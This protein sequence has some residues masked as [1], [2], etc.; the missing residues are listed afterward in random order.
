MSQVDIGDVMGLSRWKVGRVIKNARERKLISIAINHPQSDLTEIEIALAK[1]FSIK[2]AI[3]VNISEYDR[4]SP[5][6]QLG[7]AGAR[8]L[9]SIIDRHRILGVTWGST[10]EAGLEAAA[11]CGHCNLVDSQHGQHGQ[12]RPTIGW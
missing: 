5:L 3:V 12:L 1:K 10:V 4:V 11:R 2:E 9:T 8:Y 7:L 6:D